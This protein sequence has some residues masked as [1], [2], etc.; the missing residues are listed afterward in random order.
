MITVVNVLGVYIFLCDDVAYAKAVQQHSSYFDK[1]EHY[2]TILDEMKSKNIKENLRYFTE[3]PHH[4]GSKRNTELAEHIADRWK[5]SGFDKT[6]I[7]RYNIYMSFPKSPGVIS[8]RRNGKVKKKLIIKNE[9]PFDDSEKKGKL[10]Y[11][12]NAFS[13]KGNVTAE[14]IYGNYGRGSDFRTLR[15]L[16]IKMSGKIMIFRYG[17]TYR[18]SKVKRA[19][20][21]G[22]VGVIIFSD[23]IDFTYVGKEYPDGWMLN[24]YGVQRGT[25]NRLGGDALSLGYPSK[26]KYFRIKESKY[27]GNPKIP[28]Q[29]ISY[30]TAYEILKFMKDDTIPLPTGFQG[31]LNFTYVLSSGKGNTLTLK[32]STEFKTKESLTVC[33]SLYGREESDRYVMLGNHR[34]S[35][36]YGASDPSSGTATMMEIVR[37]LGEVKR[38]TGWR[39]RRSIMACSWGA[40]E[41]G[42]LGSTEWAD[43]NHRFITEH[44]IAYLNI[45]MAVEGNFT[46]R[47]KALDFINKGIYRAAKFINAPDNPNKTLYDDWL[48]KSLILANTENVSKPRFTTPSSGSD[49]KA[50]WHTYGTTIADFRYI[51]SKKDYP[52]LATN[53]HYHTRYESFGWM[54]KHVD[55]KFIYHL[56]IGKLWAGHTLLIAESTIIPFNL[57]SYTEQVKYYL[58]HFEETYKAMLN[59]HQISLSFARQ[60]LNALIEKTRLFH[61]YLNNLDLARTSDYE[62]RS[63]NDKLMNFERNFLITGMSKKDS[64]RHV[65]Y[66]YAP[67]KLKKTKFTGISE[68]IYFASKRD[69]DDWDEVRKQITLVIWCFDTANRSLDFDEWDH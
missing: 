47:L 49:Y 58:N 29:P 69:E 7:F 34:D 68:A 63:I 31:G 5:K 13:P 12:F 46:V 40:E 21:H 28:S 54:S 3:Y 4:P 53:G 39:P 9:P 2:K 16:G 60:R 44:V 56:T 30:S 19:E 51:F 67:Y 48:E 27:S 23:P 50:F 66:S 22:A 55:P 52:M 42:V 65:I 26:P 17:K 6:E 32:V 59:A 10:L 11:P 25:I 38:K 8:L 57:V 43:E 24:R 41:P 62:L 15:K 14:F 1:D 20:L 36:T 37:S 61:N 33:T 64:A 18:G 35:W 45:D